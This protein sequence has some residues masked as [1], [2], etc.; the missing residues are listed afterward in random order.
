MNLTATI[1]VSG[2]HHLLDVD[3]LNQETIE[4]LLNS[5][6]TM[7]Q[8]FT[9]GHP[10]NAL[11]GK[12]ISLLFYENSTRTRVSFEHAAI[13]LGAHTTHVTPSASSTTKGESL[14]NTAF[15][16]KSLG[17]DAIVVRHPSSGA[18]YFLA[19]NL[20]I[21]IVNAGDGAHAHPTQALLDVLSVRD[22]LGEIDHC[23]V[24]VVGDLLH[25]RVA[26]SSIHALRVMGA[27]V[28]IFAPPGMA[29]TE[30][31][32]GFHA[33]RSKTMGELKVHSS[34]VTAAKGADVVMA[35]RIQRERH[36]DLLISDWEYNALY[37]VDDQ[38]LSVCD[39]LPI[40]MH[41]GPMNEGLEISPQQA[42]G[43]NSII[44]EQ[45]TN[46]VAIRMAVL[47]YLVATETDTVYV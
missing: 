38:L 23:R 17:A 45:I 35:L 32:D 44:G 12:L 10:L 5:A 20:A 40:V 37:K 31:R 34:I 7:R 39:Q 19:R 1:K 18:P 4:V 3:S 14:L 13:Q 8:A 16:L 36:S 11:A 33:L 42:R 22:R 9:S 25:S 26:R 6:V 43:K 30:W 47:K 29:P 2:G 41:P 28:A 24:T 21:P 46:G 15:T 27:D